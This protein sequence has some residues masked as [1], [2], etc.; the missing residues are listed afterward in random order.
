[1]CAR[2][3][4]VVLPVDMGDEAKQEL[5]RVTRLLARAKIKRTSFIAQIRSIHNLGVRVASEPNIGSSFSVS[6]ADLDALWAQF[7]TEDNGVLDYL[8]MLD[9]LDEYSP[10]AIAEV[11]RL[12]TDSKAVAD[13]LIPK[14]VEALDL[15]Y[16]RDK[17]PSHTTASD[18]TGNTCS[19]LPETPLP[20]FD[21]DFQAW[22]TFRD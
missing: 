5:E 17:L 15:S 14:G 19:R 18:D 20:T 16:I 13:S 1:M 2:L 12:I 11:R 3:S 4:L 9:K 22:P 21:G 7:K 6:A 8:V 10:D